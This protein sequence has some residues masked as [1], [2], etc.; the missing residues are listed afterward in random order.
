M[1]Y[2]TTENVLYSAHQLKNHPGKCSTLH[3]HEYR[4]QLTVK[5]PYEIVEDDECNCLYDFSKL[6]GFWKELF[7]TD[8]V[9]INEITQEDNPSVEFISK[10]IY[11]QLKPKI[12]ELYSVEI[13]ETG[14][15]S[16][17]YVGGIKIC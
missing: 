4:I 5:S 11:D 1:I 15:N 10:W 3:G 6:D 12:P 13:H 16:C 14:S 7:P 2:L 9:D 17:R 8:H